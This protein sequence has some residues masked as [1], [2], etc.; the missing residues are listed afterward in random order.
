MYMMSTYKDTQNILRDVGISPSAQQTYLQCL[1]R[2]AMTS[3]QIAEVSKQP[4]PT[5]MANLGQLVV[6]GL[7]KKT[8][9]DNKS[10]SY[11][12]LSVAHLKPFVAKQISELEHTFGTL[13]SFSQRTTTTVVREAYGQ[14]EVQHFLELALRC[15]KRDWWIASPYKNTVRYMP[16]SYQEYFK[17]TREDRQIKSM[18]I[19]NKH[20]AKTG[21][22][23][24]DQLMRKPRFVP[25][26]HDSS[27]E[28][29][30]I[31]FDDCLLIAEGKEKPTAILIQSTP[32]CETFKVL[33]EIA[34]VSLRKGSS[35]PV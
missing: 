26:G 5:I 12:M 4:K 25:D 35:S 11:T 20:I 33:F 8:P 16:K 31:A 7:C 32:I 2:D 24:H 27:I 1:G 18:S 23:L 9:I 15:Q 13:D 30:I 3:K 10:S 34:W 22:R 19:W 21:L 17:K 29:M 14:E 6:F 28:V